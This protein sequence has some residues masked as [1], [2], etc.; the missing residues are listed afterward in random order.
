[1]LFVEQPITQAAADSWVLKD[2]FDD[3]KESIKILTELKL[4]LTT[5]LQGGQSGYTLNP[6]FRMNIK[7][8]LLGGGMPWANT[9][10]LGQDK[11]AKDID[12]I[13]KYASERWEVLLH[14][15][16]GSST[17]VVSS[18]IRELIVNS[19]LMRTDGGGFII[20]AKGFQF[21]LMDTPSQVW[22]FILQYLEWIREKRLNLAAIICF[23]FE[24]SFT[25]PGQD[26]PADNRDAD[27]VE[28]IQHL[29]EVG[30]INQRKRI[31]R[32]FYPTKLAIN[33][34][35]GMSQ[36]N[37][38][39]DKTGFIVVETN[40]RVYAYTESDL[41][42]SILSLFCEMMYRFPNVCVGLLTRESVQVAVANGIN[43]SQ[44]LHFLRSNTSPEMRKEDPIIPGTVSDQIRLWELERDRLVFQDG[45]LYNQ[46]LTQHDF[47]ILRNYAKDLGALAWENEYKRYMVVNRSAHDQVKKYWKRY[48]KESEGT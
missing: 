22:F 43:A 36:N 34:F 42:Y 19:G 46:F 23:L 5:E 18:S 4:W 32:R 48:K 31:S 16:V 14:F 1:M 39:I 41:Q 35:T 33:L 2:A 28:C 37:A 26:L 45:V 7:K 3:H 30:L 13:D 10:H 40:F 47:E 9:T 25:T 44:I 17:A 24:I 12:S 38:E 11:Y 27:V 29:R 6:T 15:L 21:L 20:T 8:V